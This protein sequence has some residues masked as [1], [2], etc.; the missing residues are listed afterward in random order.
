MQT[1]FLF[2]LISQSAAIYQLDKG[3]YSPIKWHAHESDCLNNF[4]LSI[5]SFYS[6]SVRLGLV[7]AGLSRK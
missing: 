6:W 2:F 7:T 3:Q 1:A 5:S 4:F